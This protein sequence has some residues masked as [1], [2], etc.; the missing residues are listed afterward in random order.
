MS[1]ADPPQSRKL[2]PFH[3]L[4]SGSIEGGFWNR[5][6]SR[7]MLSEACIRNA[8]SS[9]AQGSLQMKNKWSKLGNWNLVETTNGGV[10]FPQE[11][12]IYC[13]PI[14]VL[15]QFVCF[16]T[17]LDKASLVLVNLVHKVSYKG[18]RPYRY[19]VFIIPSCFLF[20][21][22]CLFT[23][24]SGNLKGLNLCPKKILLLVKNRQKKTGTKNS[25]FLYKIVRNVFAWN[26][27]LFQNWQKARKR[28]RQ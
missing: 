23:K 28:K 8:S 16:I 27:F 1:L 19:Q 18:W 10:Q 17:F 9:M 22:N 26:F 4:P 13:P 21:E 14:C 5:D 6:E 3:F 12:I 20:F 11:W 25:N 24:V 7:T 2:H 15:S